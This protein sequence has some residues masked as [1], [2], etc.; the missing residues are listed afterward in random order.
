MNKRNFSS[1]RFWMLHL[2][3]RSKILTLREKINKTFQRLKNRFKEF[4]GKFTKKKAHFL[5]LW[6]QTKKQRA[7]KIHTKRHQ[8]GKTTKKQDTN[9]EKT[10]EYEALTR[11]DWRK[12]NIG[13]LWEHLEALGN[14]FTNKQKAGK[15]GVERLTKEK[16]L[17]M[18]FTEKGI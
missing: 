17:E 4:I 6:T 11:T 7:I 13:Y 5:N 14:R 9:K 16:L 8:T 2:Y 1:L 10:G 15:R 18:I 3:I 12:V